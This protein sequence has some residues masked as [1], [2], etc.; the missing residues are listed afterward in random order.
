VAK[1]R[2]AGPQVEAC[3]RYDGAR[4]D[5]LVVLLAAASMLP[6]TLVVGQCRLTLDTFT[7]TVLAVFFKLSESMSTPIPVVVALG[8]V[9]WDLFP[10]GARFGGA[11]ANFAHH[12]AS[13]GGEVWLVT[14]VGDDELGRAALE[15]LGSSRLHLDQVA[16]LDGRPTG[17]VTVELNAK[18]EA[19]YVFGKDEAW[20]HLQWSAALGDLAQRCDAVC[21]GTLGQRSADSR[22]VITRFVGSTPD[23]CL[24]VLDLNLRPP[25]TGDAVIDSS[26]E[27]A[28]VLKLNDSELDLLADHLSL[29]KSDEQGRME[30]I[31]ERFDLRAVAVTLGERGALLFRDGI[32]CQVDS[33]PVELADTVGAG[34]AFTAVISMGL[35]SGADLEEI[36]RSACR[37]AEYVCT[38]N[39]ATPRLPESLLPPFRR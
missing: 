9:L 11:P 24:R 13:L 36:G 14:A 25:F 18:G 17:R 8:E 30:Q 1:S 6:P 28:N 34:D 10:D 21:F 22:E 7:T 15:R 38:Q 32:T 37:V 29:S 31:A 5:G 16:V 12:A 19:S 2:E 27:L 39:G 4:Y 3:S 35:V 33:Q 23:H 26:L 20:D